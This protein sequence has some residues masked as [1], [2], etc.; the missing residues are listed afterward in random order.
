MK[1]LAFPLAAVLILSACGG[2]GGETTENQPAA[3]PQPTAGLSPV[4]T[5]TDGI[6]TP[7]SAYFDP[8]SRFVFTSQIAGALDARD[9]NGRIV[10]LDRMGK[11]VSTTWATGLNAPK[12]LRVCQGTLWTADLDEVVGIDVDSGTVTSRVKIAGA[13]F[14]NDVAC[15]RDTVYISDMMA[16]RIHAIRNGTARVFAEGEQLEFPN[17]L[18]LEDGRLIVAGWGS[19][20]KAD[21]TTDVPGHLFALDLKTQTKTLI[22]PKPVGNLD[23]VESDGRGGYVVSDYIAGKLIRVSSTGESREIGRFTAG[24][25]DIGAISD[26]NLVVVPHMNDNKVAAYDIAARLK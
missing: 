21:F 8:E 1:R 22:T 6:E 23:G 14:L 16:N 17:G 19:Q 26:A 12:G 15:D 25:A 20:P 9:G 13:K 2:G 18:L 7:E 3:S 10:K 11:V 24:T 5:V 4:W